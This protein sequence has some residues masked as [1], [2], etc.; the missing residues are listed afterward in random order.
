VGK[1]GTALEV[2]IIIHCEISFVTIGKRQETIE[3]QMMNGDGG[4]D[5]SLFS[6]QPFLKFPMN[7]SVENQKFP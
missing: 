3:V 4:Y 7:S 6:S 5:F 1:A 2:V